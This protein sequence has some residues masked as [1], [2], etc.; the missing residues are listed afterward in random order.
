MQEGAAMSRSIPTPTSRTCRRGQLWRTPW[1]TWRIWITTTA[2]RFDPGK[3]TRKKTH[4]FSRLWLYREKQD[5]FW[6]LPVLNEEGIKYRN[7]A[8]K[9]LIIKKKLFPNFKSDLVRFNIFSTLSALRLY[10]FFRL[11]FLAWDVVDKTDISHLKKYALQYI[12]ASCSGFL[13]LWS[14]TST[15]FSYGLYQLYFLR[16]TASAII[17]FWL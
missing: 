5:I 17:S 2:N 6:T 15:I 9:I 11:C 7:K 14:T 1:S 8:I 3:T 12:R 13:K 16:F 10:I 4:N